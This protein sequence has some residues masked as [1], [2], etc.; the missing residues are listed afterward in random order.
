MTISLSQLLEDSFQIAWEYLE[1]TGEL[2]AGA[3][4]SRFLGDDR[5]RD[6]PRP[7]QQARPV[8]PCHNGLSALPNEWSN[9]LQPCGPNVCLNKASPGRATAAASEEGFD[10]WR[11][12]KH[13]AKIQARRALYRH[14]RL[15]RAVGA[16]RWWRA[17]CGRRRQLSVHVGIDRLVAVRI[18]AAWSGRRAERPT[19][20]GFPETQ[21]PVLDDHGA[22]SI[23]D[24]G[25][26]RI[27]GVAQAQRGDQTLSF[28]SQDGLVR[29]A[30]L[31]KVHE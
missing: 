8:Q 15:F 29:M 13:A 17:R 27:F 11:K 14:R 31:R 9:C 16:R 1:R 7:A 5:S 4:A 23:Y 18:G 10:R 28:T 6:P 3:I 22:I 26:H 2:G 19:L 30:D 12:P 24:T 21:R 20:C 25:S